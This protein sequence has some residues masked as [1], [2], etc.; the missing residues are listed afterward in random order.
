MY[1]IRVSWDNGVGSN[2]EIG[3]GRRQSEIDS[4]IVEGFKMVVV[5]GLIGVMG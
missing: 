4:R 2:G 5:D 3:E 1:H